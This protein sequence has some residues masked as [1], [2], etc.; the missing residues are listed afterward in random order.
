MYQCIFHVP[1]WN[2]W[3]KITYSQVHG[4]PV[5]EALSF[6]SF[7]WISPTRFAEFTQFCQD[8]KCRGK[9]F[10]EEKI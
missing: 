9:E 1:L 7:Q 10:A 5:H 8:P 3:S 2:D 4:S 6:E